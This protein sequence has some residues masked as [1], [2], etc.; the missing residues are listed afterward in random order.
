MVGAIQYAGALIVALLVLYRLLVLFS[1]RRASRFS[2]SLDENDKN[3]RPLSKEHDEKEHQMYPR[4]GRPSSSMDFEYDVVVVGSGYGGG[5]AASRL[6]RAG[7]RIAVLERGSER[8]P[9]EYPNTFKDIMSQFHVTRNPTSHCKAGLPLRRSCGRQNGLYHLFRAN[10][11]DVLTGNGLGGTSLINANVFLRADQRTLQLPEWP[12]EIRNDPSSLDQFFDRAEHMLQP[13]PYPNDYPDLKKL[14]VL[15][16]QAHA[17]GLDDNFYRV[18]QTTFFHDGLN[19]SGVEMKASTGSGQDCTGVNDGSKNSVLMTY[20]ADAWNWGAEIFCE[21]DV[22]YVKKDPSGHGYIVYY[23][24]VDEGGIKTSRWVRCKDLCVLGAGSL[25]TTEILLRSK[26]HGL[27]MSP[28]VGQKMSGNGD[29]LSFSYN[30]EEVVNAVGHEKPVM[31]DP[32]GPTITGVIDCRE[33]DA[34][35]NVLAG[36]V[37]QE[38]AVP[39]GLAPVIRL[40]LDYSDHGFFSII[41]KLIGSLLLRFW[42]FAPGISA[43][44]SSIYKTQSYL[45]MS[46]DSNEGILTLVDGKPNLNF[47]GVERKAQLEQLHRKLESASEVIGGT[48]INSPP[49]SAHPLGGARMSSDGT[50]RRGVVNHV[51]QVFVGDGKETHEGLLCLDGAVVPTSLGVNPL[52]TITALAERSIDL[53]IEKNGW[54]VDNAPNGRL[55]LFGLPSK[56]MGQTSEKGPIS[57]IVTNPGTVQFHETMEGHVHIGDDIQDFSTAEQVARHASSSARLALHVILQ[58]S[59]DTN[60]QYTTGTVTGTVSC[61]AISQHPLLIR[62]GQIELFTVDPTVSDCVNLTYK[63]HLVSV[64]GQEFHLEGQKNIDTSIAFSPS[65]T[66]TATT[67]LNTT[68]SRPDGSIV[69]RGILRISIW[70]FLCQLT[71]L[72]SDSFGSLLHFVTFFTCNVLRYFL[73]PFRKLQYPNDTVEHTFEKPKPQEVL[74]HAEDGVSTTLKIWEPIPGVTKHELPIMLI[75]GASVDDQIFS[76]ATIP[77]NTIDYFTARGYRCYV[78][79]IRFGI[80][81][82][83]KDGWTAYDSRWDVKAAFDYVREQENGRKIYVVCHCLGSIATAM[84]LLTG[85]VPSDW[86]QGMTMSQV[87]CN[88]RF[89]ADNK[90][91]ARLP[92]LTSIYRTLSNSPWLSCRAAPNTST[93]QSLL[94]ALLRLYPVGSRRELCSSST[95]HRCSLVFGRCFSHGKLNRATHA[96]LD[97]YFDGIHMNFLSH[98]RSMGAV[99]PYHVRTN[100]G[101]GEGDFVDLV[102][103]GGNLKRLGG[104][105][106]CFLSG[107]ANAVFDPLSTAESYD[108]MRSTFGSEGYERVVVEGYGHLDT[109]MGRDSHRDVYPRVLDHVEL[110]EGDSGRT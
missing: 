49:V 36:H 48:F 100:E 83:A 84:A 33:T 34:S 72:R 50:G 110:C 5:V 35:S 105:K 40:L 42:S 76:L 70:N 39:E 32:C 64:E 6:A 91:K 106:M 80:S 104:L 62:H 55:D 26:A 28:V 31:V 8:W 96:Y 99:A 1:A 24:A 22:K 29:M 9:G 58:Q 60:A 30:A 54:T 56:P 92:V 89:S 67:A 94:D 12:D 19:A 78:P 41:I 4:L 21:C 86:I 63:L 11:Q 27:D 109:W 7:K 101:E 46:H 44:Q 52:A 47:R 2:Q 73:A 17:L 25:G 77:T 10:E 107:G 37:I 66:W 98:L 20:I 38:G 102:A 45:V 93:F 18:P 74:L 71:T 53:L 51:G 95:C 90:A 15:E 68:I 57:K 23:E 65:R 87:F 81:P 103:Q 82:A 59:E 69:G 61:G 79:I 75:P 16:R 88:L 14:H 108:L 85:I 3:E 97:R 13:T 43:K